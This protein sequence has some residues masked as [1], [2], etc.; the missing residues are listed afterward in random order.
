MMM[1]TSASEKHNCCQHNQDRKLLFCYLNPQA[2]EFRGSQNLWS[3]VILK[4]TISIL[5]MRPVK[6]S[7]ATVN[8]AGR[9]L[10]SPGLKKLFSNFP[11]PISDDITLCHT[12]VNH[13]SRGYYVPWLLWKLNTGHESG[14]S[15]HAAGGTLTFKAPLQIYNF[16]SSITDALYFCTP[17]AKRHFLDRSMHHSIITRFANIQLIN[18]PSLFKATERVE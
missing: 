11:F 9:C 7:L 2:I 18:F 3:T 13:R 15:M 4:N 10:L 16:V 8:A 12:F 17:S 5:I 14:N 6:T 1:P